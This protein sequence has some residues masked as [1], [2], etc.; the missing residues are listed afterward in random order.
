MVRE[1]N[2][3]VLFSD[4]NVAYEKGKGTSNMLL[5][6]ALVETDAKRRK[7]PLAMLMADY[8][9]FFDRVCWDMV[10]AILR[11]QGYPEPHITF[12]TSLYWKAR[13]QVF[14]PWGFTVLFDRV[15]SILQGG[16]NSPS[17]AKTMLEIP[18]RMMDGVKTAYKAYG[19]TPVGE[20][21]PFCTLSVLLRSPSTSSCE[22]RP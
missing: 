8:E 3:G 13:M 19:N 4:R 5:A 7:A 2:R 11:A 9:K 18:C 16:G 22:R 6:T 1:K 12:F 10:Q 20:V 14:T 21:A 17:A 15:I